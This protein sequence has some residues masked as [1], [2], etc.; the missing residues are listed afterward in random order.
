MI[1]TK[2]LALPSFYRGECYMML[3]ANLHMTLPNHNRNETGQNGFTNSMDHV[4][5]R[6][7][8]EKNVNEKR[9]EH[10]VLSQDYDSH[11]S[12]P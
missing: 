12:A 2:K 3:L 7:C 9:W 5:T 10:I 4:V 11:L 8:R 6:I 1:N